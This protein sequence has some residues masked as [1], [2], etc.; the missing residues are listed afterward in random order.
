MMLNALTLVGRYLG[1]GEVESSILSGSTTYFA[2]TI[3]TE[4]TE[5]F[6]R[7]LRAYCSSLIKAISPS[8]VPRLRDGYD[9]S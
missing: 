6:L 3:G 5:I 4:R 7:N 8:R 1:K 2:S 9:A